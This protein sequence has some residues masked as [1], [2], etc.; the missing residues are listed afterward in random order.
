M[1]AHKLKAA[2]LTGF[3]ILIPLIVLAI[4]IAGFV[5]KDYIDAGIFL[6]GFVFVAY[7]N[8]K[9]SNIS[10]AS[11]ILY[12]S[13]ILLLVG[14]LEYKEYSKRRKEVYYSQFGLPF[15]AMRRNVG[16][17]IIPGGWHQGPY[18]DR[19][20]FWD[21]K[22]GSMGHVAKM[23]FMDSLSRYIEWEEDR[24]KLKEPGKDTSY[25][26]IRSY[27]NPHKIIDSISYAYE[28]GLDNKSISRRQA[29]SIFEAERIQRDY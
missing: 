2:L 1:N 23:I 9:I 18:P 28:H 10:I 21:S 20:I 29:D 15:N 16:V 6:F 11:L 24:Y 12:N 17:P 22:N 4:A 25:V 26:M 27:Y 8:Y 7:R 5:T 19:L 14:H 13:W 3:R